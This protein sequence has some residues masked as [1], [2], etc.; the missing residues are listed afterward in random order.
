M[1]KPKA[2]ESLALDF[3]IGGIGHRTHEDINLGWQFDFESIQ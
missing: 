2:V 1:N 3:D